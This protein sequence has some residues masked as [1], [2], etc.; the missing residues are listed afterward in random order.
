LLEEAP[1]GVLK[2]K[3]PAPEVGAPELVLSLELEL[4]SFEL[5][6]SPEPLCD[7]AIGT[8]SNANTAKKTP[9][10]RFISPSSCLTTLGNYGMTST[11]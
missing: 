8:H 5:P 3:F 4:L 9:S 7:H 2:P 11:S 6:E 1:A 10:C